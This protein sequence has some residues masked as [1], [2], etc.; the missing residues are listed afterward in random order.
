MCT[1]LHCINNY[2][3]FLFLEKIFYNIQMTS[4]IPDKAEVNAKSYA[5][6]LLPRLIEEYKSLLPSGFIFQPVFIK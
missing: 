4:S 2:Y 5:E 6:T 1:S 3:F